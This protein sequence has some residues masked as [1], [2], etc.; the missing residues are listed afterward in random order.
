[1]VTLAIWRDRQK[2]TADKIFQDRFKKLA[3]SQYPECG[4]NFFA[5]FNALARNIEYDSGVSRYTARKWVEGTTVPNYENLVMLSRA[6]GVDIDYLL[7]KSEV[8]SMEDKLR[9]VEDEAQEAILEA[10]NIPAAEYLGLSEAATRALHDLSQEQKRALSELLLGKETAEDMTAPESVSEKTGPAFAD[11]LNVVYDFIFDSSSLMSFLAFDFEDV[12][13]RTDEDW[14]SGGFDILY[15]D[16]DSEPDIKIGYYAKIQP[17]PNYYPYSEPFDYDAAA[18]TFNNMEA[19]EK[20]RDLMPA[21]AAQILQQLLE[22]FRPAGTVPEWVR[23]RKDEIQKVHSE[24]H[25]K[26]LKYK[27]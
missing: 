12:A 15:G 13:G 19:H 5:N 10:A 4:N 27:L 22:P 9:A 1:M 3:V 17:S 2:M 11:L 20:R 8:Q 18:A 21:K 6:Y 23:A 7:G 26:Y 14:R 24:N 25:K 16:I